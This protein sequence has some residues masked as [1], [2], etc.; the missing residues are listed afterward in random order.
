M[1]ML[2]AHLARRGVTGADTDAF[3]FVMPAG[4]PLD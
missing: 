4:G 2:A 3:V 1:D